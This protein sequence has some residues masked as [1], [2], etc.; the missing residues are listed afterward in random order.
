LPKNKID[1]NW[2]NNILTP[3]STEEVQNTLSQL[4]NGKAC[5]PSGISYE[6]L[7]HAGDMFIQIITS[8]LNKCLNTAQIPKQWKDGRIFPISKKPIFDGNL[9]NT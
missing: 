8:L 6:M 3:I 9:N 2:Y 7:K 4:P 1:K 5:G